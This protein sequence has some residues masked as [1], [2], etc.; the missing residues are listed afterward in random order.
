MFIAIFTA[1]M[2]VKVIALGFVMHKYAYLR[3]GWN[4]LDFTVVVLS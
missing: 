4:V 2:I 3:D 1:E